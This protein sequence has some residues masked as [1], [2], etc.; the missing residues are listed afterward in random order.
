MSDVDATEARILAVLDQARSELA[1]SFAAHA[2]GDPD[3]RAAWLDRAY[4]TLEHLAAGERLWA[5]SLLLARYAEE[6][7]A[8]VMA[9]PDQ[10]VRPHRKPPGPWAIT[11]PRT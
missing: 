4:N 8:R 5:I 3:V 11:R 1:S 7:A 9:V 10:P 2:L 6:E